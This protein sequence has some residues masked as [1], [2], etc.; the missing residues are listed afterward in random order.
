MEIPQA[1]LKNSPNAPMGWQALPN[2]G[3]IGEVNTMAVSGSSLFVGGDVVATGDESL[4]DLGHV[5]RYDMDADTWN[6]LPNKGLV[7]ET[8][9]DLEVSGNNL[10]A[11]GWDI[12]Q[13]G[14]GKLADLGNIVHY[15]IKPKWHKM[16]NRGLNKSVWAF[17]ASGNDVYVGGDFTRT[18][19]GSLKKLGYIARYDI[20]QDSAQFT[21]EEYDRYGTYHVDI[22][23]IP[24]CR[25]DYI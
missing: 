18:R 21:Q 10:F 11:G 15:D 14:D 23:S 12:T 3:L 24:V 8:I 4:Q 9:Y 7:C 6:A 13:T 19:D 2:N 1:Q 17:A 20:E 16:P 22:R 5:V 25:R